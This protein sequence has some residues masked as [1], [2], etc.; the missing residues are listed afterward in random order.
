LLTTAW[1]GGTLAAARNLH[2]DG[3]DVGSF[4]REGFQP[5]LWSRSV[6]KTYLGPPESQNE[7]FLDRLFEIGACDPGQV[8]LPASDETA[9]LYTVNAAKLRDYFL[10]YQPSIAA[11]RCILDKKHLIPLPHQNDLAM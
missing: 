2:A 4:Q 9:W 1:S 5:P 7:L 6:S 10:L 3:I 8:L 11:L